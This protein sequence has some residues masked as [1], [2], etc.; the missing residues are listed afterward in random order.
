MARLA[1][2]KNKKGFTLTEILIVSVLLGV[3]F[4]SCTTAYIAVLR[5][6]EDLKKNA[7]NADIF[8]GYQSITRKISVAHEAE[9]SVDHQQIKLRVDYPQNSIICNGTPGVKGDDTWVKYRIDSN[10]RTGID[11][12]RI[13]WSW[14][15]AQAGD[16]VPSDAEHGSNQVAAGLV[17]KSGSGSGFFLTN[18][19]GAGNPTVVNVKLVALIGTPIREVAYDT[20]VAIGCM[21]KN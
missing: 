5:V 6:F 10:G 17:I 9:I 3:V 4:F 12:N 13:Y 8:Y 11:S 19:T 18:V 21:A 15:V 1:L 14:D 16:V 2:F 7:D 20:S